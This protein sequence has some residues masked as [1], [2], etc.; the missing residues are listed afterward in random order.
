MIV[1]CVRAEFCTKIFTADTLLQ[2][3]DRFVTDAS[4]A[5]I[6]QTHSELTTTVSCKRMQYTL[7]II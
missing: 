1:Q 6:L 2:K 7:K 5:D 3:I 4:H